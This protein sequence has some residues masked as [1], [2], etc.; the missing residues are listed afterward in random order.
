MP[1]SN[2]EI[3]K[4]CGSSTKYLNYCPNV[5]LINNKLCCGWYKSSI[6]KNT[7]YTTGKFDIKSYYVGQY[8]QLTRS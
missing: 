6:K 8:N 1:I 7:N 4:T 2:V 3:R 5:D